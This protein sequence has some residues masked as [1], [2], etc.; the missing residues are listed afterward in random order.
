M[1]ALLAWPSRPSGDTI[2][3]ASGEA[4]SVRLQYIEA[5]GEGDICPVWLATADAAQAGEANH[6]DRRPI[7]R[8]GNHPPEVEHPEDARD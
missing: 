8:D 3:R 4:S 2:S 5:A 6:R 1:N 7:G